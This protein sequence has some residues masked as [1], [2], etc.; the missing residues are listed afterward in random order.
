MQTE[1][2]SFC[3]LSSRAWNLDMTGKIT[4]IGEREPFYHHPPFFS[5][6]TFFR[7]GLVP[8]APLKLHLAFLVGLWTQKC[9]LVSHTSMRFKISQIPPRAREYK[10][11]Y[12]CEIKYQM[13]QMQC[14]KMQK[15]KEIMTRCIM[16]RQYRMVLENIRVMDDR[17]VDYSNLVESIN[18]C[19]KGSSPSSGLRQ[20]S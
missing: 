18:A 8:A 11:K 20:G 3:S 10:S 1:T 9:S 14:N 6:Q 2:K 16:K 5:D 7:A 17:V 12:K 19:R 13:F 4:I 15:Y